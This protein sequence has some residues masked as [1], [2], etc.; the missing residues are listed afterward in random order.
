VVNSLAW[1]ANGRCLVSG[2]MDGTVRLWEF[3]NGQQIA[4]WKGHQGEVAA[5][6]FHPGRRQVVSAGHDTTLLVWDTT[7]GTALAARG[8]EAAALDGLWED[9]ASENNTHGNKALWTLVA[10]R[11][12]SVA[13]LSRRVFVANPKKIEQCLKDLDSRQFKERAQAMATLAG[14]GRW[15]EGLL[16]KTLKDRPPEEVRQRIMVLL[17]RLEGKAPV[18]FQQERL[19][20][21]RVIEALE[22][23]ATPAAREL[24]QRLA[25][26]A[27]EEDLRDMARAAL[28][29]LPLQTPSP[30]G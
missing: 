22:Q 26:G 16:R 28:R 8:L 1:S 12:D 15:V 19:R 10:G 9:L 25:D 6:A 23:A 14:Y 5:V 21:R 4:G 29:R 27:A 18:T 11:P 3:V 2:G 20:V 24:L 17:D 7:L 30:K 13:Y